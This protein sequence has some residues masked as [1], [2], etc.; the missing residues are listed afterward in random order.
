MSALSRV[1]YSDAFVMD[2]DADDP[3]TPL[4]WMREILDRAPDWFRT[5]APRTWR[6]LGLKHVKVG[7]PGSV[8]GWP[9]KRESDDY[10]VLGA[11]S[12]LG[13]PAELHLWR[14]APGQLVFATLIKHANPLMRFVWRPI[15]GPH[16][17][18]VA[19]LLERAVRA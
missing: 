3:R 8:L 12:R 14:G 18:I 16:Q 6:A 15:I 2:V 13:M 1:D 10:V 5:S 9:V 4:E 7:T 19:Q 11:D 17:R